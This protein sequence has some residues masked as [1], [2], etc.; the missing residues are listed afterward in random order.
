MILGGQLPG[1]VGNRWGKQKGLCLKARS[2]LFAQVA[3]LLARKS[4]CSPLKRAKRRW[5][6]ESMRGKTVVEASSLYGAK[7][8]RYCWRLGVEPRYLGLRNVRCISSPFRR[9]KQI[10]WITFGEHL[11]ILSVTCQNCRRGDYPLRIFF[12]TIKK[13]PRKALFSTINIIFYLTEIT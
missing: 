2:F 1:K 5:R 13:E 4:Q 11:L 9:D 7:L 12:F 10:F 3:E 6:E 8:K